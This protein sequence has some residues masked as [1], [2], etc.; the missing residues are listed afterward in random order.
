MATTA[1]SVLEQRL[2]EQIGDGLEFDTST[3]ITTNTSIIATALQAYDG[4][5]DDYFIGWW[6]YITEGNNITVLREISDYATSTGTLTVRGAA[7]AAESGAV[8]CRLHRYDRTLYVNAINDAIRETFPT[9]HKVFDIM[10]L[11]AGNILPNSHFRDWSASTA[12]DKYSMQDAN[13]TA[14]ANTTAGNYRGGGKSMKAATGA[15]GAGKYVYISSDSYPR[16]LDL[17][18]HTVSFYCWALPEVANDASI[19]IYTVKADGTAQTLASTT[20]NPAGEFTLL[21]LEDQSLNDD[22]VEVQ[23]RFKITTASKYV[24]FDHAKVIGRSQTEYLLPTDIV[25]GKLSSVEIQ[26]SGYSDRTCD[27]LHPIHWEQWYDWDILNDGTDKY[28]KLGML[29]VEERL[30]RLRGYAPL[31]TVSGF[32][33][34]IEIGGEL[35]NRFIAYAK[36]KLYQAIEGPVASRDIGKYELQSAKAYEE[37]HRLTHLKMYPPKVSMKIREY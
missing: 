13:I 2:A 20:T 11:V 8:T 32:T 4:G 1:L 17:M 26:T 33:D 15:S 12:P 28:L 19:V 35:V 21:K 18:G 10:E 34:T 16:L 37:Y 36:Y 31:S 5:R 14:T 29:P 24:Y 6:V 22:L 27:D 25:N 3:N 30:I 9:F 7:L 23:V